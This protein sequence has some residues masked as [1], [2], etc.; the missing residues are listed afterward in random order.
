M[1]IG[2]MQARLEPPVAPAKLKL[3]DAAL[4]EPEL[5][6]RRVAAEDNMG[7]GLNLLGLFHSYQ[8]SNSQ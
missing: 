6:L 8:S 4:A 5:A 2:A 1:S 7:K 3:A